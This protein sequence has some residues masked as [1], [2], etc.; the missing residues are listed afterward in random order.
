MIG[1]L[2]GVLWGLNDVFANIF[3]AHIVNNLTTMSVVIFALLL[4]LMQD[5]F[6]C[7][8]IFTYQGVIKRTLKHKCI[9]PKTV[10]L[11][12]LAALCAGPL[13]MVAGIAGIAYAGPIYAGVVTSCYP[14]TALVLAI[15]FLK[16]RPTKLKVLGITITIIA[17][18]FISTTAEQSGVE[19]ITI[20]LIFATCAMLGW[21]ME[22]ILFSIAHRYSNYSCSTLLAIRQA[23]SALS[24]IVILMVIALVDTSLF[25]TVFKQM[26]LPLLMIA[27]V[28]TAATSYL[29]YYNAIHLVGA[30]LATT[31]NASFIFWAGLFSILFQITQVHI[32]FVGW[33]ALLILGVYF[34]TNG[35]LQSNKVH[36]SKFPVN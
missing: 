11:L 17:V 27:C 5:A 4:S 14:V 31:F 7:L 25:V 19:N 24:Y 20:G 13:G 32:S 34:A 26:L 36:Y 8:S 3:S 29:A 28:V 10:V 15:L 12:C 6:S 35:Q 30:S 18:I 23:C 1:I 22:S 2:S 9:K 21:G 16:E 33:G